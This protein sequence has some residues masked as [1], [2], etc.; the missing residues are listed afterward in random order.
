MD[1]EKKTDVDPKGGKKRS[2]RH[3]KSYLPSIIQGQ[4]GITTGLEF[5]PH[6]HW[7][8]VT[9]AT[10]LLLQ[11]FL[12]VVMST[13]PWVT[14]LDSLS[15]NSETGFF[16]PPFLRLTPCAVHLH[17]PFPFWILQSLIRSLLWNYSNLPGAHVSPYPVKDGLRLLW[18]CKNRILM[19][20]HPKPGCVFLTAIRSYIKSRRAAITD[21]EQPSAGVGVQLPSYETGPLDLDPLVP[22]H[23]GDSSISFSLSACSASN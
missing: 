19:T 2:T 20:T 11:L 17:P 16:S 12:P 22:H 15:N 6:P 21:P 7:N 10:F 5:P 3:S 23:S 14:H 13:L 4:V 18:V 8:T 9:F 1:R